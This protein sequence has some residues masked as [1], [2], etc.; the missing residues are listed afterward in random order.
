MTV[1]PQYDGV[2][3][4]GGHD[5]LRR[6]VDV[7]LP[8]IDRFADLLT[9]RITE[10]EDAYRAHGHVTHDQLR[11]SCADNLHSMVTQLGRDALDLRV[12]HETGRFKAEHGV[13]LS[14]VTHAYRL[15]GRFLWE[16]VLTEVGDPVIRDMPHV[17]TAVW[18]V[19]DTFT[20]AVA[21]AYRET[22]SERAHRDRQVKSLLLAA[23]LDGRL[24]EGTHLW[25]CADAL[26]LPQRGAFVV[27]SAETEAGGRPADE[28][29]LHDVEGA[30]RALGV[31]SVWRQEDDAQVGLLS[32]RSP[33]SLA[34]AVELLRG[35]SIGRVGV[36]T[37]FHGLEQ[38]PGAFR[39]ARLACACVEPGA[40][41]VASY[42]DAP[43]RLMVVSAPDSAR[44]AVRKVLRPVLELPQH[45][46]ELLLETLSRWFAS[47]GSATET[48]A[49]MYCHRNTV[50]YRL[51]RVQELTGR[52]PTDPVG[53]SEIHLAL[54]AHRL[55]TAPPPADPSNP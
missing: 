7:L 44:H 32:L 39:Q 42:G 16:C 47:G 26:R 25:E 52:S 21:M 49:R 54:E 14:A 5:G 51:R 1:T 3:D 2:R 41:E 28:D 10:G 17:A 9:D 46:R 43:V 34:P 13:P 23:L 22:M 35:R 55:L 18:S 40:R 12:P 29:A 33:G 37:L 50:T 8:G 24:D 4:G 53:A 36:S 15:A 48:A 19:S 27:V 30:L 31:R 6:L 20:D 11:A 38:A 45:E